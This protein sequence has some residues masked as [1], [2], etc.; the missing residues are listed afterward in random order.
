MA[1]GWESKSVSDQIEEQANRKS[2]A[3]RAGLT[4]AEKERRQKR[5][6]LLLARARTLEALATAG[7]PQRRAMLERALSHLDSELALLEQ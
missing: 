4:R 5:E 1:R 7:H 2:A 6:G 3:P